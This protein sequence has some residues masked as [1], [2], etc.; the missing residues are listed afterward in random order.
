MESPLLSVVIPTWNRARLVCEAVESALAQ[1]DAHVEVIV[2]DDGSTD[3]T[4]GQLARRF[5]TRVNVLRMPRRGGIG[6]ARNAGAR[7]ASGELIAFLDSDDLWLP[8]KLDAELRVFERFPDAEAV[9]SDSLTFEEGRPAERTRFEG[10]GLLAATGGQVRSLDECPWLWGHWRNTITICSFT[11]RRS[12]LSRL[13]EPLFPEDVI[14]GEDWELEMRI[15]N[16][17]RVVVLP[18]VWTH[19]RRFDDG[20]RPGRACPGKP[21]THAQEIGVL[22]LKLK[23]LERTLRLNSLRE[24]MAAELERCRFATAQQ[25]AQYESAGA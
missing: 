1:M 3:D 10:N 24:E 6:A 23:I 21:L 8:A 17:C 2:V 13:G 9:V 20:T 15:Y 5:G 14:A 12:A 7:E 25:L 19:I 11:V 4:A 16:E 18:E 22:R